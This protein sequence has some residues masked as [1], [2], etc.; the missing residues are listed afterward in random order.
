[1]STK[2]SNASGSKV[3]APARMVGGK[4]TTN[5]RGG[6]GGKRIVEVVVPT[7]QSVNRQKQMQKTSALKAKSFVDDEA[8]HVEDGDVSNSGGEEDMENVEEEEEKKEKENS[9]MEEREEEKED[10]DV[11]EVA[12]K[13]ESD[14]EEEE[15]EVQVYEPKTPVRKPQRAKKTEAPQSKTS[16][17]SE[18]LET[19]KRKEHHETPKDKAP[20]TPLSNPKLECVRAVKQQ[21]ELSMQ[22]RKHTPIEIPDSESD[23]QD[24]PTP[25]QHIRNMPLDTKNLAKARQVRSVEIGSMVF[26]HLPDR[27]SPSP[28]P[29]QTSSKHGGLKREAEEDD[30]LLA[31]RPPRSK[32]PKIWVENSDEEKGEDDEMLIQSTSMKQEVVDVPITNRTP[33]FTAAQKGKGKPPVIPQPVLQPSP[34]ETKPVLRGRDCAYMK[35]ELSDDEDI[36]LP[37]K[38]EEVGEPGAEADIPK[39][40]MQE[41]APEQDNDFIDIDPEQDPE[42]YVKALE[43][44]FTLKGIDLSGP[45]NCLVTDIAIQDAFLYGTYSYL[46]LI[47]VRPII[48][49]VP[50]E[51]LRT[52]LSKLVRKVNKDQRTNI[53]DAILFSRRHTRLMNAARINPSLLSIYKAGEAMVVS[54]AGNPNRPL[55][56]LTTGFVEF[57]HVKDPVMTTRGEKHAVEWERKMGSLYH[58]FNRAG[59]HILQL[60]TYSTNAI[61]ATRPKIV[62]GN[63]KPTVKAPAFSAKHWISLMP[64]SYKSKASSSSSS[65]AAA[66][67]AP[68]SSSSSSDYTRHPE[69]TIPIIDL[70]ELNNFNFKSHLDDFLQGTHDFPTLTDVP[71]GSLVSIVHTVNAFKAKNVTTI[72]HLHLSFNLWGILV[73]TDPLVA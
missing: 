20:L 48:H 10:M 27:S 22:K 1:M 46:D 54:A 11:D 60:N 45:D 61:F 9:D 32:K 19:P 13:N 17:C 63:Y 68:R 51:L 14:D 28:P 31:E 73:L 72:D 7:A 39:D 36:L 40:A 30:S 16:V 38:V 23:N 57:A 37:P 26:H 71:T 5:A 12:V 50:N 42:G 47:T 3:P 43:D 70:R 66:A 44:N 65:S 52:N 4:R 35:Q 62:S 53:L 67:A 24:S 29:A 49:Y 18:N 33:R 8:E 6:N 59:V 55:K 41:P 69:D 25:T 15:E 64:K 58:A 21:Q 2:A 34:K 56:F